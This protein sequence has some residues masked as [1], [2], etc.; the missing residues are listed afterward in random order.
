MN[1]FRKTIINIISKVMM[2]PD[3]VINLLAPIKN[4]V[5]PGNSTPM[6]PYIFSKTGTTFHI[7][8]I[9][10]SVATDNI[11]A[12]YINALLIFDLIFSL[13]SKIPT[14]LSRKI[15][16]FPLVSPALIMFT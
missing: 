4:K 2:P 9:V 1:E 6:P 11:I 15:S 8:N 3:P 10:T 12:G 16:S 7:I 5:G 13:F 14:N